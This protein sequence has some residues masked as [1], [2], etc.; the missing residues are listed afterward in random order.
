MATM[1]PFLPTEPVS[2]TDEDRTWY[3][4]VRT[5]VLVCAG[6]FAALV[7]FII[8]IDPYDSGRSPLSLVRGT[9]EKDA[10]FSNASHGR[11]PRFNAAI[12]GNSHGQPLDP[13]RLS[14]LLGMQ[15]VQMSGSGSSPSE[16]LLLAKWFSRHRERS[17]IKSVIFVV[18]TLWCTHDPAL[19][20]RE[21]FPLWLYGDDLLDYLQRMATTQGFTRARRQL[22]LALGLTKIEQPSGFD[23]YETGVTWNFHPAPPNTTPPVPYDPTQLSLWFPA[24]DRLEEFLTTDLRGVP[25]IL[26]MP[27]VYFSAL[28]QENSRDAAEIANC[29]RAFS[30]LADRRAASR[31]VDLYIDAPL[32]HDPH[33][34]LDMTHYRQN[35]AR[36]IEDKIAAAMAPLK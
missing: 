19:P 15:F 32:A 28:P 5:F 14:Q 34:F 29:K 4:W 31:F 24:I 2:P 3:K 12:F 11:N 22:A 35:V 26:V 1:P 33:N 13:D 6:T 7:G 23:N 20:I 9:T 25:V 16:Q 21:V 27:Y 18:D 36:Q 10:R 8:L 17:S 30:S